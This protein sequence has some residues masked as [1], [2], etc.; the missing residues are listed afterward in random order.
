MTLRLAEEVEGFI[1]L[2]ERGFGCRL[3]P[4]GNLNG[5]IE[6]VKCLV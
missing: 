1:L 4:C 6:G 5:F 3:D 2:F